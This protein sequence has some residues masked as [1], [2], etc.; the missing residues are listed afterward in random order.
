[1]DVALE[2]LTEVGHMISDRTLVAKAIKGKLLKSEMKELH[3]AY[4]E[5]QRESNPRYTL[6]QATNDL[7]SLAWEEFL[8]LVNSALVGFE[9]HYK[10]PH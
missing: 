1:M 2:K 8:E 3:K 4:K 5:I 9:V 7:P 6:E 10:D